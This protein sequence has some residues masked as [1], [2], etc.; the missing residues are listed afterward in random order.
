[1]FSLKIFCYPFF[2]LLLWL[3]FF[4]N[5]SALPHVLLREESTTPKWVCMVLVGAMRDQEIDAGQVTDH[6]IH[7]M[8]EQSLSLL[9]VFEMWL[10]QQ[11]SII[12]VCKVVL[13]HQSCQQSAVFLQLWSYSVVHNTSLLYCNSVICI[14]AN[15]NT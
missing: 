1:M 10:H 15:L 13:P 7:L 9:L 3:I 12:L 4:S 6:E 2:P 5:L 8:R 11:G 14:L